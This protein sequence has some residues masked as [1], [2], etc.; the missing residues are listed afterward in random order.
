VLYHENRS[1]LTPRSNNK[2]RLGYII[3]LLD[4]IIRLG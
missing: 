3:K 1:Q 4:L 2:V